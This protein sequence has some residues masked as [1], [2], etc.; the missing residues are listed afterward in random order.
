MIQMECHTHGSRPSSLTVVDTRQSQQ[1]HT[2]S[3]PDKHHLKCNDIFVNKGSDEAWTGR[4][5]GRTDGLTD[6]RTGG[7]AGGRLGARADG[8]TG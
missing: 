6:G 2:E 8:R 4:T 1:T 3:Y 5:D 7:R